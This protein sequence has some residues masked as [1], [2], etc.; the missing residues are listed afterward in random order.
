MTSAIHLLAQCQRCEVRPLCNGGCPKDRFA[1]SSD[2]DPGQ[3]YLCAGLYLFFTHTRPAMQTMG[4]LLQRGRPPSDVMALTA[5]E[6]E[7]RGPYA[8][9]PCGSGQKFRFC[10]GDRAPQSPFSGLSPR[11]AHGWAVIPC[12][13]VSPRAS[14]GDTQ[15]D[16]VTARLRIRLDAFFPATA[17]NRNSKIN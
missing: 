2:G 1:L 8:P 3:N 15:G 6:D 12:T 4:Q 17:G 7:K 10:H 9:C 16:R 11:T 14:P 5:A 13:R